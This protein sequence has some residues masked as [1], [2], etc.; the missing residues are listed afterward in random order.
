[1][2]HSAFHQPAPITSKMAM[3]LGLTVEEAQQATLHFQTIA[4]HV[5]PVEGATAP[6]IKT[7]RAKTVFQSSVLQV[8]AQQCKECR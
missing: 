6:G 1:M 3:K 2:D 4:D 7:A 8:H 5:L